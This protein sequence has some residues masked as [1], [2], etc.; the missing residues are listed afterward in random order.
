MYECSMC[1]CMHAMCLF[2]FNLVTMY[3]RMYVLYICIYKMNV[4]MY[5]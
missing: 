4:K 3:V 2:V 1:I 5:V